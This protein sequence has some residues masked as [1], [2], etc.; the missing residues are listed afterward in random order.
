MSDRG[1]ETRE[2]LPPE[3]FNIK[4]AWK[5]PEQ[6]PVLQ[7]GQKEWLKAEL[8][9]GRLPKPADKPKNTYGLYQWRAKEG[10]ARYLVEE[11]FRFATS[12]CWIYC[13]WDRQTDRL[14]AVKV[15]NIDYAADAEETVPAGQKKLDLEREAK[16]MAKINC[17]G[18]VAV[19]DYLQ[20]PNNGVNPNYPHPV[21]KAIVEE[22]LDPET[23]P[24]LRLK[25]KAGS[26]WS[27]T[28]TAELITSLAETV[29]FMAAKGVYHRDLK[30]GNIFL[31]KEGPRI[32]D[33][34]SASP[35]NHEADGEMVIGTPPYTP[36]ERLK[37]Q[38]G[39]GLPGEV[40]SLAMIAY[41]M[42]TGRGLYENDEATDIFKQMAEGFDFSK[43]DHSSLEPKT[44]AVFQKALAEDQ[45][46][47]YQTAG[48]FA[49]A[50]KTA[51]STS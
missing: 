5:I 49:A 41:E 37:G 18:A 31:C 33:F 27:G 17:P 40:F 48:D 19:Y 8:A 23:S 12:H 14:V 44:Q 46:M 38:T 2:N 6:I 26:R 29:D 15:L 4:N 16:T 47:R 43:L 39:N 34:G 45:K 11:I 10:P 50:L 35:I 32:G 24:T 30:P 51:I 21:I 13:G 9:S 42:M 7:P 1:V 25:M 20:I 3:D 22:W 36:P 28:E